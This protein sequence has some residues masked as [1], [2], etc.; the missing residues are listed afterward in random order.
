[1]E[2]KVSKKK[3]FKSLFDE[4]LMQVSMSDILVCRLSFLGDGAMILLETLHIKKI[5]EDCSGNPCAVLYR[6]LY[7]V[8]TLPI[9]RPRL[10]FSPL[11]LL[12]SQR[13]QAL[14]LSKVIAMLH[15]SF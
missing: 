8:P 1:M 14:R 9:K 13:K 3:L 7:V 15:I 5:R 2:T 6:V 4:G 10:Y 12:P 11:I